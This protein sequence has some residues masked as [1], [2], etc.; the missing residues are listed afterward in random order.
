MCVISGL[1]KSDQVLGLNKSLKGPLFNNTKHHIIE[2][3]QYPYHEPKP[4][5]TPDFKKRIY[6]RGLVT[7]WAEKSDFATTPA[8]LSWFF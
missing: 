4:V 6:L 5:Y 2:Y 3:W 8:L 1:K 7:S